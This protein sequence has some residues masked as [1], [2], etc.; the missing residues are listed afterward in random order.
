MTDSMKKLLIPVAVILACALV[1]F[2]VSAAFNNTA[3]SNEQQELDQIIQ[4]VIPGGG[5]YEVEEYTGSDSS[6]KAV[7]RN[8]NGVALR[9]TISGFADDIDLLVGVQNDGTV[10][11]VSVLDSHETFGLGQNAKN[12]WD[13]LGSL[14][15]GTGDKS[16]ADRAPAAHDQA[17]QQLKDHAGRRG[18]GSEYQRPQPEEDYRSDERRDERDKHVQHYPACILLAADMG[19]RGN[20]KVHAHFPPFNRRLAST[21]VSVSGSLPG[22]TNEQQP[23]SMQ[24]LR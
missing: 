4:L 17:E 8:D 3:V 15:G 22:Q 10:Y 7:Y 13:F 5:S 11:S 24:S 12:D 19:R 6:I 14:L 2:G 20:G 9:M 18:H 1:L 23:R 16:I 21:K